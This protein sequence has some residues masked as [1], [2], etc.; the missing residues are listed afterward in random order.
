MQQRG[1]RGAK[2]ESRFRF[3]EEDMNRKECLLFLLAATLLI[4]CTVAVIPARAQSI[5]TGDITGIVTDP[6]GAVVP[7]ASVQLKNTD[8][9]AAQQRT[10]N[11]QGVYR[12]QLLGPGNYTVTASAQVFK[13]LHRL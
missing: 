2:K 4:S 3:V 7:N 12:F 11:T 1:L 13:P 10:T 6:S 8:T 5:T 9:G